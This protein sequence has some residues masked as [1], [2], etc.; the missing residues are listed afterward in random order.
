MVLLKDDRAG[1]RI[2]GSAGDHHGWVSIENLGGD[3]ILEVACRVGPGVGVE[4]GRNRGGLALLRS[5]CRQGARELEANLSARARGGLSGLRVGNLVRRAVV[6]KGRGRH[7]LVQGAG[8]R[9]ELSGRVEDPE[10]RVARASS[11]RV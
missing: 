7:S 8:A 9:G 1:S 2:E 3:V 5:R 4:A 11:R 6:R 10:L